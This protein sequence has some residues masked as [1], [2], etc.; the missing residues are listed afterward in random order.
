M[1]N[2]NN[3]T[4]KNYFDTSIYLNLNFYK[5]LLLLKTIISIEWEDQ[6]NNNMGQILYF[7]EHT[8]KNYRLIILML[9]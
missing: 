7:M 4:T 2:D 3:F 5:Q 6:L 9:L 8:F 1:E